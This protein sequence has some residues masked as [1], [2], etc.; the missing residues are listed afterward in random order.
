MCSTELNHSYDIFIVE[1]PACTFMATLAH[2]IME[3][4]WQSE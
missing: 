3:D 1:G 2:I 4:A